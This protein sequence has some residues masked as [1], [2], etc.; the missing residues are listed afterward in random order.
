MSV[1][2]LRTL[3]AFDTTSRNS[4]LD[5]VNWA[6]SRL[7][8]AGA[9]TRLIHDA[10]GTKA[11]LVASFG[12]DVAGGIVLSAHTDTVP[13][14]GQIWTSNPFELTERNGRLHGRGAVDMKGFISCCLAAVPQWGRAGLKRPIH[15]ALSYDEEIGCFGVPKLVADL[16][17]NVAQ[18][19]LVVV[20][21]PTSMRI[22]DGHRGYCGFRTVFHG[23]ATHSGDPSKGVSA[24]AAA[25][26]FVSLLLGQEEPIASDGGRTTVNIGQIAGGTNINIVPGRCEVLWE[27]RPAADADVTALATVANGLI[28]QAAPTGLPPET[29][30]TVSIPPLRPEPGNPAIAI[31]HRLGGVLPLANLPFGTEGGFFQ[32]A[33]FPT[34]VCGPG[35]IEQAHQPD[36]WIAAEEL[37]KAAG[38]LER[39]T[40]W[41]ETA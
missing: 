23:R 2:L 16:A 27:F 5:L 34:V 4:N 33:G 24:I 21:E 8:A 18:P 6:I 25:A 28:L 37:A 19:A 1:D 3:V 20:G 17:A 35:S 14:D 12:P 7:N 26:R 30:E 38:F 39:V 31:A 15:L 11:N 9:R 32:A 10:T 29:E 13:V 36:E 41:A 22:A 40:Q